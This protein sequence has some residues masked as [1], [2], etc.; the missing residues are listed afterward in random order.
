MLVGQTT[1]AGGIGVSGGTSDQDETCT[2]GRIDAVRDAQMAVNNQ[3]CVQ[4]VL[5]PHVLRHMPRGFGGYGHTALALA[6]AQER[7]LRRCRAIARV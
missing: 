4:C 2:Q 5:A 1:R 7:R 3:A 6:S